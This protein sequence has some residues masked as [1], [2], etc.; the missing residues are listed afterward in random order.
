MRFVPLELVR[1]LCYCY[2][3]SSW[4]EKK[5]FTL[6]IDSDV[7]DRYRLIANIEALLDIFTTLNIPPSQLSVSTALALRLKMSS[8]QKSDPNFRNNTRRGDQLEENWTGEEC[9]MNSEEEKCIQLLGKK[10]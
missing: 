3:V 4:N 8:R 5:H 9:G 7:R 10:S 6:K 1:Y 2:L